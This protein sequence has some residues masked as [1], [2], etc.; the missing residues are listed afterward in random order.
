MN[1]F[2]EHVPGRWSSHPEALKVQRRWFVFF[3]LLPLVAVIALGCWAF[4]DF[5]GWAK[6]LHPTTASL[7]G[8]VAWLKLVV[9]LVCATAA[10]YSTILLMHGLAMT[11]DNGD[12][13]NLPFPVWLLVL[14][15]LSWLIPITFY[16]VR[17]AFFP[18]GRFVLFNVLLNLL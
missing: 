7:A 8:E 18:P 3:A 6:L 17:R 2:S 11:G 16:F 9:G 15:V 10:A 12:G 13:D 1:G 4:V 5:G 14:T